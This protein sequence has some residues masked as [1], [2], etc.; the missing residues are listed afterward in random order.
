M[1]VIYGAVTDSNEPLPPNYEGEPNIGYLL[2]DAPNS[3]VFYDKLDAELW[4]DLHKSDIDLH[5]HPDFPSL[6][7]GKTLKYFWVQATQ[8]GFDIGPFGVTFEDENPPRA[9]VVVPKEIEV[10]KWENGKLFTASGF[11]MT[12]P[13]S[14]RIAWMSSGF[15]SML[16]NP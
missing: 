7:V 12:F 1:R 3:P 15:S 8:F 14:P 4:Y 16:L 9:S 2:E 5:N 10:S 13:P 6:L 11:S